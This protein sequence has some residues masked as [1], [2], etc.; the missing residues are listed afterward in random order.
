MEA[1]D[2]FTSGTTPVFRLQATKLGKHQG[3]LCRRKFL[4]GTTPSDTNVVD[5]YYDQDAASATLQSFSYPLSLKDVNS[6]HSESAVISYQPEVLKSLNITGVQ[7][8][9]KIER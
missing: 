2:V 3:N 7:T 9:L 6:Q 5:N 4:K 8:Q 1:L